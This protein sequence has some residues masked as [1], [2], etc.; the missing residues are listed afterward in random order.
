MTRNGVG[1]RR[2][3]HLRFRKVDLMR[4]VPL[5]GGVF[6]PCQLIPV[7]KED[8]RN[9]KG[10]LENAEE[11]SCLPELVPYD[12]T[13]TEKTGCA[14]DVTCGPWKPRMSG[15][16]VRYTRAVYLVE[17]GVVYAGTERRD[18]LPA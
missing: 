2:A 14:L 18:D 5:K 13:W 7:K 12:V 1:F 17:N 8:C 11:A 15:W 10:I 6:D 3:D 16:G 9:E 4:D